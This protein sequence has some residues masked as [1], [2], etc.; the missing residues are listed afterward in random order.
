M[1]IYLDSIPACDG[2][3]DGRTTAPSVANAM[4]PRVKIGQRLSKVVVRY[5]R[6]FAHI[7]VLTPT[8]ITTIALDCRLL[9]Y[10]LCFISI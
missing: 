8:N 9:D 10:N 1:F 3:T 7:V 4:L 5:K 2:Q 6:H